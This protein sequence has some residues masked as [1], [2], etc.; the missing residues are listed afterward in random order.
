MTRVREV[1]FSTL[2]ILGHRV[3]NCVLRV[4]G[5]LYGQDF[6]KNPSIARR[7]LSLVYWRSSGVKGRGM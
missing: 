6:Q 2:D 4:V 3:G 1:D 7:W 5:R